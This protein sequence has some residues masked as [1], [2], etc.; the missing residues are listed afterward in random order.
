MTKPFA[1][2]EQEQD[3]LI[4]PYTLKIQPFALIVADA[5][6]G[7]DMI[8]RPIVVSEKQ[9]EVTWTQAAN[10]L[11]FFDGLD[12]HIPAGF[13]DKADCGAPR[14]SQG[15]LHGLHWD[16]EAK[17]VSGHRVSLGSYSSWQDAR[18]ACDRI[19]APLVVLMNAGLL[20]SAVAPATEPA[21]RYHVFAKASP[22]SRGYGAFGYSND[23]AADVFDTLIEADRRAQ[24]LALADEGGQGLA[25]VSRTPENPTAILGYQADDGQLKVSRPLPP[26]YQ[27]IL[28]AEQARYVVAEYI[29]EWDGGYQIT[30]ECL[31]DLETGIVRAQLADDQEAASVTT[32]DAEFVLDTEGREHPVYCGDDNRYRLD[33][34]EA[35]QQ[36]LQVTHDAS[37]SF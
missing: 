37:P 33:D 10:S 9:T 14:K 35:F 2:S 8:R 6:D 30:T 34:L 36:A 5:G 28:D 23:P 20:P 32:L 13:T 12:V 17:L 11:V 21:P 25:W 16:I 15:Q 1:L 26:E 19:A 7:P 29:S 27:A 24:A 31:V 22:T 18:Q 3:L 4:N